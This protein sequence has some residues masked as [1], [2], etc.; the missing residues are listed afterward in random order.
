MDVDSA[1]E[2]DEKNKS[3]SKSTDSSSANAADSKSNAKEQST[4]AASW[5][6]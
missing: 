1:T 5:I 3:A 6:F 4:V 2:K